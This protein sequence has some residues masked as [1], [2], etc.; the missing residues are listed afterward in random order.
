MVPKLV[1][2]DIDGVWTDGGMYYDQTGNEFKKFNT[3]DSAG[4]MFCRHYKIPVAIITGEETN[5][6]EVLWHQAGAATV[7]ATLCGNIMNQAV[8][9]HELPEPFVTDFAACQ[10]TVI[11]ISGGVWSGYSWINEAEVE[12]ST[13]ATAMLPP[14]Y[15]E[16][17]VTDVNGCIGDTT[18]NIEE[19]PLP[20]ASISAP[21]YVGLCPT[22]PDAYI[23][24]TTTEEGYTYQWFDGGA[25]MSET[26]AVFATNHPDD[27]TLVS[28][29]EGLSS[30][31]LLDEDVP[32]VVPIPLRAQ[33]AATLRS[34]ERCRPQRLR[35]PHA[36]PGHDQR[37]R[38]RRRHLPRAGDT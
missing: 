24:A 22:G 3:S 1:I 33:R 9:V 13:A 29:I 4:V 25:L 14:G 15:F 19:L 23:Y 12:V 34:A 26:S 32:G 37:Q 6:I 16:L 31:V 11:P 5:S 27:G 8:T 28:A 21:L 38:G 36:G 30:V 20:Q 10:N 17:I 35:G 18:F 2:T 7:R